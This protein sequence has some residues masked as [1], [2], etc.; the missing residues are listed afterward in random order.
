MSFDYVDLFPPASRITISVLHTRDSPVHNEFA[1][2]KAPVQ[3]KQRWG[4][5]L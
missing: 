3:H 2:P 5:S 1:F 4:I